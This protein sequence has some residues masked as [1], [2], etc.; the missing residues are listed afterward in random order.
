MGASIASL[1]VTYHEDNE[2]IKK[3]FNIVPAYQEIY[4]KILENGPFA[5]CSK[6]LIMRLS[7]FG[8]L[9]LVLWNYVE[10]IK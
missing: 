3:Y 8:K 7:W 6:P 9:N 5:D 4:D 10:N 2:K 1:K